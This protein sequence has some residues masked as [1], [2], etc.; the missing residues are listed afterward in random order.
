MK[1]GEGD[2]FSWWVKNE[3][4]LCSAVDWIPEHEQK[5]QGWLRIAQVCLDPCCGSTAAAKLILLQFFV[6]WRK[7]SQCV[8]EHLVY[9]DFLLPI[10]SQQIC[11]SKKIL[12][13][14]KKHIEEW[15]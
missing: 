14:L 12:K 9:N 1:R 10:F 11:W 5:V 8:C 6:C 7:V 13:N 15:S 2:H 4:Y 3:V